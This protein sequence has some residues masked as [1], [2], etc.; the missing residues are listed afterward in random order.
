MK[1][2]LL[3][4]PN[5]LF[6]IKYINRIN[7]DKIIIWESNLHFTHFNFHKSKLLLHRASMKY[8]ESYLLEN[9]FEVEYL[10][11]KPFPKL[12]DVLINYKNY[13][14]HCFYPADYLLERR[15]NRYKNELNIIIDFHENP[16]FITDFDTLNHLLGKKRYF[17]A[18]FYM[19]QRKRLNILVDKDGKPEGGK[20]SFD[21]ENRKKL[22]NNINIYKSAIRYDNEYISEAKNYINENFSDNYGE[23]DEFNYPVTH[24]EAR[25]QLKEFI[26]YKLFYFGDY[27]DAISTKYDK[28]YHSLLTPA[29]NIGLLNP[30]EIIR[31]VLEHHESNPIPMNSLEGFIRQIIGWREFILGIYIRE[32]VKERTS[33]YWNFEKKIP[34]SFYNA[35][36][37]IGPVDFVIK[38]LLKTGYSH[39]IERLMILGNF[40]LLCEIHPDEVYKWF[41]EMYID[42]YDWVMVANVYGMSQYADGGLITTKPYISSSNYILKMSDFQKGEWCEIWDGLYWRFIYKYYDKMKGNRRMSMMLRLLDKMDKDKLEKHIEIAEGFLSKLK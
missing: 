8:Y 2:I 11:F 37:G 25:K 29:L 17:M 4:F 5:Q 28:I 32:G 16:N 14:I 36:T 21:T 26:N 22:P 7:P 30:D 42:S 18:N 39:H 3:L 40:M 1:N 12:Y 13:K 20:W 34:D 15:L 10:E 41:M 33:N 6:D 23:F 24:Q 19:E 31:D 38:K 35:T 9:S 27:E